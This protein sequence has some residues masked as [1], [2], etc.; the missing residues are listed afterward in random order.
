MRIPKTQTSCSSPYSKSFS[1]WRGRGKQGR[2]EKQEKG[3]E[4]CHHC[5]CYVRFILA[6]DTGC[7]DYGEDIDCGDDDG[8]CGQLCTGCFKINLLEWFLHI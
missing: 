1:D 5:H 6:S 3:G 4:A 8:D 7:A 2:F